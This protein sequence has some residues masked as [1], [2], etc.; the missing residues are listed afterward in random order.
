MFCA[1]V[2]RET[3]MDMGGHRTGDRLNAEGPKNLFHS[4]QKTGLAEND[5]ASHKEG[6]SF[7]LLNCYLNLIF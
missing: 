5:V 6:E 3:G 1:N 2:D 4:E 7:F